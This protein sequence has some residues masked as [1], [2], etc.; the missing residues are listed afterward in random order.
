MKKM[1]L[2][3]VLLQVMVI[4][5]AIL[6]ISCKTTPAIPEVQEKEVEVV[7]IIEPITPKT[8]SF[9]EVP[10]KEWKLIEV[11]VNE[12]NTGF[13]RN[14]PANNN[15]QDIYTLSFSD[16]FVSGVGAPNRYSA[17][18]TAGEDRTII[19]ELVRATLMAPIGELSTLRE[20][21]YFGYIQNAYR[22]DIVNDKLEISSKLENGNEIRLVF[23]L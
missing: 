5:I 19:I 21:D 11:Y 15:L 13:N 4:A 8:V 18:Y 1:T 23:S 22:W 14:S 9:S 20:Y 16:E 10:D 2:S 6:A 7:K 17:P 12:R 3:A